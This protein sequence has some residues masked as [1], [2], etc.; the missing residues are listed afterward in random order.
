MD[1][2][3]D[4]GKRPLWQWLVIYL[5]IGG[6]IYAAIYYFYFAKKGTNP[7]GA[8][9]NQP[10]SAITQTV[11]QNSV[12]V[13]TNGFQPSSLTIKAGETIVWNNQSGNTGNVSSSPHP[14]HTDYPPLNLGDI[15]PGASVSL[16]FPTAGTYKYHNHLNPSQRGTIVVE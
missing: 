6:L 12:T 11:N 3:T 15:A 16:V 1:Y 4:Y 9:Y 13:T 7:Y 10:T 5:I 14:I 2:P 8:V